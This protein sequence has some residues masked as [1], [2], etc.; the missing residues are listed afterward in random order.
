[1]NEL[2][3]GV[4][5]SQVRLDSH[6]PRWLDCYTAAANDLKK[7]LGNRDG[8][9]VLFQGTRERSHTSLVGMR[10]GIGFLGPPDR[11]S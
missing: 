2:I 9:G 7:C 1:M 6:D 10:G 8:S 11:I 3:L 4:P 5:G